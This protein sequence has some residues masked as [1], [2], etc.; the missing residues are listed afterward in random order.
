MKAIV[1]AKYGSPDVLQ[2]NE[3]ERPVPKYN[4]VLV[5]VHAASANPLDWHFMRGT[6]YIMRIQTGLFRPKNNVMGVDV[7]GR[8]EAVGKDVKEFQPGDEVFGVCNGAFAEYVC[9][10]PR[11]L[12]KKPVN[13]RF[14]QAAA[15]PIAAFTALQGLCKQGLIQ[16]GQKV[17][18]NGA[19]GGVGTFAVQIAKS[20]GAEVTGVCS[21]R[22]VAMVRSIGADHVIDYTK[23]DFALNR[24]TYDLIFDTVGNRSLLVCRRML[25]PHGTI[26]IVGSQSKGRWLGPLA[27]PFCGLL[28][29]RFVTQRIKM[30]MATWSNKDLVTMHELLESGKVTPV[31]DRYYHLSELTEAIRYLE[32]GHAQGKVIITCEQKIPHG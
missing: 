12:V 9:A 21:T 11:F 19:A 18:I 16:P 5:H 2:L 7:A 6:P 14:E 24:N 13:V 25:K 27:R 30:L 28:M 29:S 20:L 31:I 1:Y 10:S 32:E 15:V 3:V 26:V 23:E 8:I 17:L 22:N 4:E